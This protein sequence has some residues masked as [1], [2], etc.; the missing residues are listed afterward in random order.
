MR[1]GAFEF[2]QAIRTAK[3]NKVFEIYLELQR[4]LVR[5]KI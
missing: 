1:T 3:D 2:V 4:A 5:A